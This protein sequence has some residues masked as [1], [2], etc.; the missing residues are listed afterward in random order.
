MRTPK[1]MWIILCLLTASVLAFTG[2]DYDP[3]WEEPQ[4]IEQGAEEPEAV[5]RYGSLGNSLV[6][7]AGEGLATDPFLRRYDDESPE[8]EGI[9]PEQVGEMVIFDADDPCFI[10][11]NGSDD[12]RARLAP[13]VMSDCRRRYN[14]SA[15]YVGHG[16][17]TPLD[18]SGSGGNAE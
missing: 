15:K 11:L 17:P 4:P 18:P 6:Y 5:D 13:R 2:C 8:D 16:E 14:E 10:W 12:D 3:T 9:E 7:S 1:P